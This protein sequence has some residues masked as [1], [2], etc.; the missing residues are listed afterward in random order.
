[1]PPAQSAPGRFLAPFLSWPV[2]SPGSLFSE[3]VRAQVDSLWIMPGR[4]VPA[5]NSDVPSSGAS[6]RD[7]ELGEVSGPV[8]GANPDAAQEVERVRRRALRPA[9]RDIFCSVWR[10]IS[11]PRSATRPVRHLL[12][13]LAHHFRVESEAVVL[14]FHAAHA[15]CAHFCVPVYRGDCSPS[16]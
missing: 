2:Q 16:R 1:M 14:V 5:Q 11:V 4:T 15:A 12:R 10:I 7:I 9:L 6:E 3:A 13:C 8:V